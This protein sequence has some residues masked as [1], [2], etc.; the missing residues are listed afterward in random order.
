LQ[1][2]SQFYARLYVVML[3]DELRGVGIIAL[4]ALFLGT[5]TRE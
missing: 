3:G 1:S 4:G 2:V 5:A